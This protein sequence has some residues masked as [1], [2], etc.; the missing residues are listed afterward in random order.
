MFRRVSFRSG[1]LVVCL[2]VCLLSGLF[3]CLVVRVYVFSARGVS[4]SG[5]CRV[6]TV[7]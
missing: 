5:F 1:L 3:G 7:L 2:L 6:P 4:F